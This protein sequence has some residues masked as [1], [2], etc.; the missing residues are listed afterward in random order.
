M[1]LH[2]EY[3]KNYLANLYDVDT[4][5]KMLPEYIRNDSEEETVANFL[6]YRTAIKEMFENLSQIELNDFFN[7]PPETTKNPEL[8][9]RDAIVIPLRCIFAV[10][11]VVGKYGVLE[12]DGISMNK[13]I[14]KA[15]LKKIKRIYIQNAIQILTTNGFIFDCD[16]FAKGDIFTMNFPDEPAVISGLIS[17]SSTIAHLNFNSTCYD[18]EKSAQSFTLM[19]MHLYKWHVAAEKPDELYDLLRFIRNTDD[20]RV[21]EKLHQKMIK[22]GYDFQYNISTFEGRNAAIR[23]QKGSYDPYAML[24]VKDDGMAYIGLKMRT[25]NKHTT[26]IE[27]CSSIFKK[28]FDKVWN[29][30]TKNICPYGINEMEN[31]ECRVRY[32]DE[33]LYDKCTNTGWEYTWDRMEFPLNEMDFDSYF[34]FINQKHKKSSRIESSGGI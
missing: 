27:Q 10:L 6:K 33:K 4:S 17:F 25:L 22:C 34:Y 19:N 9:I 24:G 32:S 20:K 3:A 16:V 28:A 8:H 14:F 29:D 30:C 1:T 13:S 31:C 7:F 26:Y 18:Y 2:Q 15:H 12:N 21:V 23:Y 11:Y 5:I